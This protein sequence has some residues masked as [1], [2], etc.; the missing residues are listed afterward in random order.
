ML[1]QWLPEWQGEVRP[2]VITGGSC[3]KD[4]SKSK[5]RRGFLEGLPGKLKQTNTVNMTAT[6]TKTRPISMMVGNEES[7]QCVGCLK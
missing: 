2:G 3:G 6:K 7:R 1:D 4:K 5:A